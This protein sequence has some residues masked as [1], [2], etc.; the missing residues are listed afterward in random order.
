[1]CKQT[2]VEGPIYT[3]RKRVIIESVNDQPEIICQIE[4]FRHRN[5]FNFLA[6]LLTGFAAYPYHPK[7]P[8]LQEPIRPTCFALSYLLTVESRLR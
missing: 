3:H 5:H 8:S 6:N 4:H 1:M 7:K 2:N